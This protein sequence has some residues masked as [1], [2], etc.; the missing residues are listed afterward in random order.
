M[1]PYHIQ[2]LSNFKNQKYLDTLIFAQYCII[3]LTSGKRMTM[4]PL[5]FLTAIP[6]P[7]SRLSS[8]FVYRHLF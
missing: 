2:N 7:F 5:N 8:L 3:T 6:F 4:D 1:L